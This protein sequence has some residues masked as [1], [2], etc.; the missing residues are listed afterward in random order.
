MTRHISFICVTIAGGMS[1]RMWKLIIVSS[2]SLCYYIVYNTKFASTIQKPVQHKVDRSQMVPA[3]WAVF[4]PCCVSVFLDLVLGVQIQKIS[5]KHA[6]LKLLLE[7]QMLVTLASRGHSG[8]SRLA[9][10]PSCPGTWA[11]PVS[12]YLASLTSQCTCLGSVGLSLWHLSRTCLLRKGL[13]SQPVRQH[14]WTTGGSCFS[15][16]LFSQPVNLASGKRESNKASHS[17]RNLFF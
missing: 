9:F 6:P 15:A 4:G 14:F 1:P 13:S 3:S 5:H 11:P 10:V 16:T 7:I 12:P 2:A 8:Q 17:I